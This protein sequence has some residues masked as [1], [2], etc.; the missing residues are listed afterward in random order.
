ML[1]AVTPGYPLEPDARAAYTG[2]STS[3]E[4]VQNVMRD[5]YL[6][7]VKCLQL[8]LVI[9]NGTQDEV[10]TAVFLKI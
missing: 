4:R 1:S 9:P 10:L 5:D 3:L 8:H 7:L 2:L 6:G